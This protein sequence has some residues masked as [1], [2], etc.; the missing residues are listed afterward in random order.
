MPIPRAFLHSSFNVS[1]IRAPF[2]VPQRG[3]YGDARL[4]RFFCI[5]SRGSQ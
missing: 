3:P 2:Q 1:G 5:S 4:Q